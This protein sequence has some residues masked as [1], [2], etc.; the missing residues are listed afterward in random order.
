MISTAR[1]DYRSYL[2]SSLVVIFHVILLLFIKTVEAG[3]NK[4]FL[5][6]HFYRSINMNKKIGFLMVTG[7]G[8]LLAGCGNQANNKAANS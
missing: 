3:E 5:Q 2:D 7:M 4:S 6:P 8:L 1:A